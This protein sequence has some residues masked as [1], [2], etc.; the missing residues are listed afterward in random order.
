M[1]GGVHYSLYILLV[2]WSIFCITALSVSS[3]YST[4][5]VISPAAVST[6][7]AAVL[8]A[9][10]YPYWIPLNRQFENEKLERC[11]LVSELERNIYTPIGWSWSLEW[12][13]NNPNIFLPCRPLFFHRWEQCWSHFHFIN[14]PAADRQSGHCSFLFQFHSDLH[15]GYSSEISI[16]FG[17]IN[18]RQSIRVDGIKTCTE[19][20]ARSKSSGHPELRTYAMGNW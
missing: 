8:L 6:V 9:W 14:S 18:G 2:V 16:C 7:D 10:D 12:I 15:A 13:K 11:K 1:N 20:I 17:T 3:T 4:G 19:I 5:L